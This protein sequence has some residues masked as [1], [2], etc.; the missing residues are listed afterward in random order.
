MGQ[1]DSPG[2]ITASLFRMLNGDPGVG[3]QRLMNSPDFLPI[4][5]STLKRMIEGTF[6][7]EQLNPL[8]D[9][10][11]GGWVTQGTITAMKNWQA[12]RNAFILS[13]IPLTLTASTALPL[14]SGYFQTTTPT[15][16]LSG[17]GNV[18]DTR[19]I[20]VNGNLANWS[21]FGGTW[22]ISGVALNPGINRILVQAFGTNGTEIARITVDIW[23]NNGVTTPAS[24]EMTVDTVWSP[25]NGPYLVSGIL[26]VNR[27]TTLRIL[28]GTT[29]YLASGAASPLLAACLPREPRPTASDS[30]VSR[31]AAIGAASISLPL[32]TVAW[33]TLTSNSRRAPPLLVIQP[34][35]M[36]TP[37]R[38][39]SII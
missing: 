13:Q 11:L 16:S 27:G 10:I 23:Y 39:S 28:P 29:V 35:C 1:G 30:L 4:Y 3:I 22:N 25:A 19:S 20:R 5:Y 34:R 33:L 32:S 6:S 26:E 9:R 8:L 12:S 2:S 18:I 31:V 21:A 15:A 37:R 7:A 24:G 38:S 36:S 17:V 14:N